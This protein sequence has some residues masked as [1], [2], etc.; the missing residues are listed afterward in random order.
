MRTLL[1]AVVAVS[2]TPGVAQADQLMCNDRTVAEAAA[3]MLPEGTVVLD[4][5]SQCEDRVRVVRVRSAGA[6][7]GC[8]WELE[9]AGRVL[10]E[11]ERPFKDGYQR[12]SA[13][14]RRDGSRY[15]RRLDLA[16]LYIETEPNTFK[17]LGGQLGLPAQV[18]TEMISLPKIVSISVGRRPLARAAPASVP[19]VAMESDA[20]KVEPDAKAPNGVPSTVAPAVPVA[21]GNSNG[22][23]AG[24]AGVAGVVADDGEDQGAMQPLTSDDVARVFDYWRQGEGEPVLA[25]M[26]ACLKLDLDSKS[27]TRFE[28]LQPVDGPVAPGT[29]VF[30]WADWLVPRGTLVDDFAIEFVFQ[31]EVRLRK[32]MPIKGRVSGPVVPTTAGAKLSQRG[33]YTLRLARGEDV[34]REVQVEVR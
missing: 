8:K 4:F 9:V 33:V 14:Y 31:G 19:K 29:Q 1:A 15:L 23:G 25:H 3:A 10:W 26:V 32:K 12:V 22:S 11:T 16:Y 6:V 18:K 7:E 17:W 5:C 34:I 2:V 21:P 27:R 28:C 30:A 20:P 13:R 24:G